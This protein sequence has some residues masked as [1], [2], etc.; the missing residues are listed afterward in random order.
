MPRKKK[1]SKPSVKII[2]LKNGE[3]L[4]GGI[5]FSKNEAVLYR[6]MS[7]YSI[8]IIDKNGIPKEET[9]MYMKNWL[10]SSTSLVYTIPSEFV[11]VVGDPDSDSIKL[12][13]HAIVS[14]DMVFSDEYLMEAHLDMQKN[15]YTGPAVSENDLSELLN[16]DNMNF[17]P[18]DGF[19]EEDDGS[20]E[21]N[22]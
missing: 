21:S 17:D 9:S 8:P 12:Y 7:L 22:T 16:E 3:L 10:D 19:D 11:L 13:N 5:T 6:P 2:K 4:I 20:F 18:S 14:E 1:I 15:G